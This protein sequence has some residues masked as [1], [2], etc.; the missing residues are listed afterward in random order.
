MIYELKPVKMETNF[1]QTSQYEEE[2]RRIL[3]G[4]AW[5]YLESGSGSEQTLR[6]TASAFEHIWLRPRVLVP[7]HAPD[8]STTVL[9]IPLS[10]P[11]Y[12]SSNWL[13]NM[14]SF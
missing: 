7:M 3:D 13:S 2:A 9:G 4:A 6:A 8:M 5:C 10:L 1:V 14:V 11:N 12:G